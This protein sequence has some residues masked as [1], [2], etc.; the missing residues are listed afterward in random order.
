MRRVG[1]YILFMGAYWILTQG[2]KPSTFWLRAE[3]LNHCHIL[4]DYCF[5]QWGIYQCVDAAQFCLGMA[6]CWLTQNGECIRDVRQHMPLLHAALSSAGR[7]FMSP[8]VCLRSTHS[9]QMHAHAPM[10]T[11]KQT[12]TH[13]HT[14]ASACTLTCACL[15]VHTRA[16]RHRLYMWR[17]TYVIRL[18]IRPSDS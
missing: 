14:D 9:Q 8:P 18:I 5:P 7:C 10:L 13:T 2:I 15:C 17:G 12:H 3:Y 1:L 11:H 4:P 16:H 6:W